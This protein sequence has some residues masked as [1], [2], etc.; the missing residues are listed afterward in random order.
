M[1]SNTE[2]TINQPQIQGEFHGQLYKEDPFTIV[3]GHYVGDDGFVVPNN[4]SEFFE[5][6]PHYIRMWV[7]KHAYWCPAAD[8]EDLTQDLILHM[9]Q[10]HP[11]SKHRLPGANHRLGGCT[12]VIETF[13]PYKQHGASERRFRN[14]V[15]L[16]L[17]NKLRTMRSKTAKDALSQQ[18]NS[19]FC[20]DS[21]LDDLGTVGDEYLHLN[22]EEYRKTVLRDGKQ[23]EDRVFAHEFVQFVRREDPTVLHTITAVS[24]TASH[25]DAARK[26]GV[27]EYDYF[28]MRDRLCQLAE[29]FV[30]GGE[31]PYPR[32]RYR[33]RKST[34]RRWVM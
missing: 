34:S 10:L 22:S 5:R 21:G 6:F 2:S 1:L 32:R 26:L 29:S 3:D 16:C 17:A 27:S 30:T 19:S 25:K 9:Q 11:S 8:A 18:G 14:Y 24:E 23:R 4:F 7:H 15:N 20:E 33:R 13:D 12:D 31:V 28:R